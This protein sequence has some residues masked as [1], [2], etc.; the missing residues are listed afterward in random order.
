MKYNRKWKRICNNSVNF[1]TKDSENKNKI[2]TLQHLIGLINYERRSDCN[3]Q[4]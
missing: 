3:L 2:V 1:Y 4:G